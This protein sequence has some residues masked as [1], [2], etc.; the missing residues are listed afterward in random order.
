MTSTRMKD[1]LDLLTSS[2]VILLF[3]YKESQ[4]TTQ[5]RQKYFDR[6]R[7]IVDDFVHLCMA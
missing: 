1:D 2:K 3:S 6:T 5:V 7:V 4:L